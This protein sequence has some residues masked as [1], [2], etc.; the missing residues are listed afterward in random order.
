M[1][2]HVTQKYNAQGGYTGEAKTV[3]VSV[4]KRG[5]ALKLKTKVKEFD[6]EAFVIITDAN[7]ILGKGFGGTL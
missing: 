3:L 5:E 1:I 4:C 2:N 6:N 7:E